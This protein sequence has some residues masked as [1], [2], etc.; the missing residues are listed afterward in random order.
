M[1]FPFKELP[2]TSGDY[3]R[4]ALPVIVEGIPRAPQLCLL[5]TRALHNRFGAWA[6]EAAGIDLAG[7]AEQR[8]AVGGFVTT[9]RERSVQLTVGDVTWEAPVWFCD[10]WPVAFH[11]LG[12]EGFF[13]WFD[14]RIRTARF[15]VEVHAEA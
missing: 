14:V 6:A 15:T 11:L 2:G 1:K 4:P 10:P 8:V 9:A 5:D 7:A 3:L 13:R 12:Q